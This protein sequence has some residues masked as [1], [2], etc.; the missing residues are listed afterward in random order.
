MRLMAVTLVP[1]FLIGLFELG[2]RV[3][4]YGYSTDF[5]VPSEINGEEF[6]IPNRK[7]THQFFPPA[8][9]RAP[10]PMRM[11]AKKPEGTYRIFLFGE[12]AAYGDPDPSFGM[13]RFL[14]ALLETRYPDT[15]FEVVCVAI[16]AIN[17]HVIL[18]IARDCAKRDGDM[19]IIYMGNNE[20]VGPFGAGTVFGRKAPGLAF[21]RTS[22]LLKSTKIGQLAGNMISAVSGG[23][24]EPDSWNGIEMFSKNQLRHDDP[25]RLKAYENFK[26][27]LHAILREGAKAG[28]PVILST[29]GSNLRDCS[30]FASLHSEHIT[31][32]DLI[33][34][35][36]FFQ[37]GLK[38]EQTGST[39]AALDTYLKAAAI[40]AGFAELQ[41]RIG[42]GY[43]D[44]GD[45]DLAA[46]AFSRA[47][48]LDGL[49]VRADTRIN[50]IIL[51]TIAEISDGSVVGVDAES[52]LADQAPDRIPGQELFYEHVHFTLAGNYRLARIVAE[53]V[54]DKLPSAIA[55]N[56]RGN[57]P[58]DEYQ[59]CARRLAIT[60]WDQ[61]RVWDVALGRISVAPFTSQSSHPANVEY[62]KERMLEV[63]SRTTPASPAK[64]RQS[65]EYALQRSPDDTL[66]RWNYAQYFEMMG[67]LPEA[68][69]QGKLI[70]ELTPH[71]PWPHYFVGSLLARQGR[72]REAVQYL[73]M[74]LEIQ[75]DLSFAATELD[76]IL[77]A[78]PYLR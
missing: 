10:L 45:K 78:R 59:A 46:E 75:P 40:D 41:F 58:Q 20:M 71:G 22:L 19:W 13:G 24:G 21:V 69:N 67:A 37:N 32:E 12:S 34:W 68:I 18:P 36:G 5:F 31:S 64:D 47:R 48:D 44:L 39:K 25:A 60:L 11:P 70:C 38:L 57:S 27:N 52:V 50:R 65:Y 72:F 42:T 26:G 55:Q 28:V 9:A 61:K 51:D 76:Q 7:F 14:E 66:I 73:R 77:A 33:S 3:V 53:A 74:A 43:L 62:C 4:G 63:D 16:T 54:A 15:D 17:S 29:V 56:F 30:P 49:A 8:L 35:N 23:S 2:L 1:L 6:L